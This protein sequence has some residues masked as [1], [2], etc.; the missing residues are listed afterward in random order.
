M[1]LSRADLLSFLRGP[2]YA[3]EA[4]VSPAG[5]P[6]AAIMGIVVTDEF[7]ILFDTLGSTRKMANLRANPRIALAIGSLQEGEHRCVQYE[8]MAD[9]PRGAELARVQQLYFAKFEDGRAR[10]SWPGITYVRVRPAWLRYCDY[11]GA[12]PLILE[13]TAQQLAALR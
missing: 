5:A 3:V 9:E 6:E 10:L 4:S 12:A 13:Y 8:G 2:R 11:S 1:A 7:E